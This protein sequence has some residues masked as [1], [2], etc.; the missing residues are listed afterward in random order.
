MEKVGLINQ[1][2][3]QKITPDEILN[4]I[5][6]GPFQVVALLLAGSTYLAYGC[7]ISILAFSGTSIE[8]E[9]NLTVTE[10]AILPAV[11][12]IPNVIGAVVFSLASD[13]FGRVWPYAVCIAWLATFSLASAFANHFYLFVLLRCMASF[14]IG[15]T[16]G[17]I[18]PTIVEFLPV[19]NRG[20]VM[21]LTGLIGNIGLCLSCGLAWWLIP[22]YPRMGW[23]YYIMAS[24][25]PAF[26]VVVFRILFHFESPRF[27]IAKGKDVRAREIFKRISKINRKNLGDHFRVLE[28]KIILSESEVNSGDTLEKSLLQQFLMIFHPRSLRATLSLS[29]IIITETIGYICSQIFLPNFLVE[30]GISLYFTLMVTLVAQILGNILLAII[31]EWPE[32]GRLNSFRFFSS[33]SMASFVLLAFFQNVI[34]I[35]VLLIIIYFAT[36]PII[37]LFYSYVSEMYPTSIRSVVTAYF[38]ILQALSNIA[39]SFA[40]SKAVDTS[41]HWL[42]PA[43]FAACYLVQLIAG[44]VLNY[45]PHGKRLKDKS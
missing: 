36:A 17:F 3:K 23:R 41:Q 21:V 11:T 26:L 29:V 6:F 40:I 4:F 30:V 28:C 39:G 19:N 24:T 10:F 27:L 32:I 34:S 42:F 37:T 31:T 45:E 16:T 35:P 7:D 13:H 22:A 38:Y 44:F 15:G 33:L 25:I 43:V 9:W 14:A 5:G 1:R 20:K 18:S 2:T 8:K 12:C